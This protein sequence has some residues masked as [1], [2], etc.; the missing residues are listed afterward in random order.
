VGTRFVVFSFSVSSHHC[1]KKGAMQIAKTTSTIN[2]LRGAT[3]GDSQHLR[4]Y[5]GK[6]M[7]LKISLKI[8][9]N[10]IQFFYGFGTDLT[11]IGKRL[12]PNCKKNLNL[13]LYRNTYKIIRIGNTELRSRQ[14]AQ[15]NQRLRLNA[16]QAAVP[17]KSSAHGKS[18]IRS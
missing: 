2:F 17:A 9:K 18:Q 7:E 5:K 8:A 14:L 4:L 10:R 6:N 13:I 16:G 1:N 3:T 11:V 15:E 12:N